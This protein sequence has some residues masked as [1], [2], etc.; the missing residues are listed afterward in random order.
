MI[1]QAHPATKVLAGKAI[2]QKAPPDFFG[3][4]SDPGGAGIPVLFDAKSVQSVR[5]SL[6]NLQ[7][8]Q[9]VALEAWQTNGGV[10]GLAIRLEFSNAT[11]ET[12]WADW[13]GLGGLWWDWHEKRKGAR[14]SVDRAW[15]HSYAKSLDGG[16]DW[17]AAVKGE[18]GIYRNW[19]AKP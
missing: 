16:T 4:I 14:A 17:L 3:V 5:F 11:V 1:F 7:R 10:A 18:A 12:F 2:R 13:R 9:A 6:G 8:H 19:R 15:L